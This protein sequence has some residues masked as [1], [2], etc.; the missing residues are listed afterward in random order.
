MIDSSLTPVL[1]STSM[2][3]LKKA[4]ELQKDLVQMLFQ[5]LQTQPLQ[6]QHP[7]ITKSSPNI[8]SPKHGK[9]DIYV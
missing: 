3:S 7:Q 6:T 2:Y 8:I 1:L 9:I 5:G 4:F